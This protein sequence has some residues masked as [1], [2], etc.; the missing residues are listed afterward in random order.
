MTQLRPA[1]ISPK[2]LKVSNETHLIAATSNRL[3]STGYALASTPR[4]ST[5][6]YT[7]TSH[8]SSA[9]C[10]FSDGFSAPTPRQPTTRRTASPGTVAAG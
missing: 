2:V 1:N 10:T 4:P 5:T 7:M 6:W 3:K 9:A 8:L